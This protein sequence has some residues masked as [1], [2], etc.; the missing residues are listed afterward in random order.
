MAKMPVHLVTASFNFPDAAKYALRRLKEAEKAK[1]FKLGDAAALGVD[2][3]GKLHIIETSEM[4][5]GHGSLIGGT[6]GAVLG[7]L[8]GPAVWAAAGVGAVVGGLAAKWHDAG[9]PDDQLQAMAAKLTPG[10]SLLVVAVDEQSADI[11]EK[12]LRHFGADVVKEIV[13]GTVAEEFDAL[14]AKK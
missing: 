8:G 4:S 3:E 9:L 5:G 7:V 2:D 6:A 10:S 1:R 11:V 14:A 13:D 12:Q